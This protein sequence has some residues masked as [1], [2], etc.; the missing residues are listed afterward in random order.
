[1]ASWGF[2]FILFQWLQVKTGQLTHQHCFCNCCNGRHCLQSKIQAVP[3]QSCFIS[4]IQTPHCRVLQH[5]LRHN[6]DEPPKAFFLFKKNPRITPLSQFLLRCK[7][8]IIIVWVAVHVLRLD[9]IQST[10]QLLISNSLTVWL[11]VSP[12]TPS[13]TVWKIFWGRFLWNNILIKTKSPTLSLSFKLAN[14]SQSQ[15]FWEIQ[16]MQ[17]KCHLLAMRGD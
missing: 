12:F 5:Q 7:N 3:F 1:M 6:C 14:L 15:L 16:E 11:L 10:S 4:I 2:T 8:A 13:N 9:Q 17:A